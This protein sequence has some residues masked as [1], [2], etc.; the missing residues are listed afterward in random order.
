MVFLRIMVT[1][2]TNRKK[3]KQLKKKVYT[4][5]VLENFNN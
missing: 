3:L 5:D 4:L 1:L 2:P